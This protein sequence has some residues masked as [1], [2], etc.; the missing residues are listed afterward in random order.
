MSIFEFIQSLTRRGVTLRLEGDR[1][2]L[3]P[4]SLLTASDLTMIRG[5]KPG[6]IAL[7][8]RQRIQRLP[9]ERDD[10]EDYY[11]DILTLADGRA[12]YLQDVLDHAMQ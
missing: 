8:Q 5:I 9:I 4:A 12:V 10:V 3:N 6:I 7:L 11:P 1:I 2:V